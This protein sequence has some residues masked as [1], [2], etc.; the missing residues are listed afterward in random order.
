[1]HE[2]DIACR[3]SVFQHLQRDAVDLLN[4]FVEPFDAGGG[5]AGGTRSRK[6]G[7]RVYRARRSAP[8]APGL[9][10]YS[11]RWGFSGSSCQ[12]GLFLSS[13]SGSFGDSK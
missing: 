2:D 11:T 6:Y 5:L 4:A 9:G 7:W 8:R 10:G 3:R 12:V 1:M 13:M